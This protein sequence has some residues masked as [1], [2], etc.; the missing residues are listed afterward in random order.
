MAASSTAAILAQTLRSA[1]VRYV[2]GQ[3][4]GEVVTLIDALAHHEIE[5]VLVGQEWAAAF[6]AATVGRLTGKP[7]V[8]LATLGPGAAHLALGV[9]SAML[10]RDPMLAI[11]ARTAI[12]RERLSEK[13]NLK[14]NEMYAPITKWSVALDGSGTA[15]NVQAALQCAAAPPHGPVFLTLPADIGLQFEDGAGVQ[16]AQSDTFRTGADEYV[17]IRDRL[18]KARRPI[19]I[20][21][22][23]LDPIRDL[24]SVR[25]FFT[26]TGIPFVVIPQAKGVADEA[27]SLFLGPVAPAAGDQVTVD[28][29]R[30]SDFLLGVG[31]DP[32]E[33]S[34]DWHLKQPIY[35]IANAPIGYED[36][37][38]ELECVGR[39]GALLSRLAGEYTGTVEWKSS[40]IEAARIGAQQAA[41]PG[42]ESSAV[43]LSPHH[44]ISTIRDLV[45]D[46]SIVSM[47]VGSHKM[48]MIHTWRSMQPRTFLVS[49]G[50][51]AMGYAVP[52]A[53]SAAF[54]HPDRPVLSIVGDGDFATTVNE[55]ETAR[56]MD[57]KPLL[58]VLVDQS[59]AI[60]KLAQDLRG[61]KH[62]GV[63]F[64]PVDWAQVSTGFGV[65]SHVAETLL[66]V[67]AVVTDWLANPAL[68]VLAVPIDAALYAGLAH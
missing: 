7:G 49:N 36:F 8:C 5:F 55:L 10:D 63:D 46:N 33:S 37:K 20:I 62:R 67:Q 68:T 27:S 35:S 11:S 54:V 40:E 61:L 52:A 45:P 38:S 13:Q 24:N 64:K 32:V 6:M 12:K 44:L 43:G 23:A 42:A 48:V 53:L 14:L 51:S 22:P 58:V 41:I 30:Q 34:Q 2:F 26:R 50:L 18:N 47:G 21:G 29:I 17:A 19:G 28:F 16:P 56:R 65:R 3:P 60:I 39:V 1:G 9:G 15:V 57:V 25:D 31:F 66:D 59:L 4:G